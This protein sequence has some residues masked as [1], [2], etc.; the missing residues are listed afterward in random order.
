[1]T[2]YIL[3]IMDPLSLQEEEAI[4]THVQKSEGLLAGEDLLWINWNRAG[5]G[6]YIAT[7]RYAETYVKEHAR[8]KL[9]VA[10]SNQGKP[11]RHILVKAVGEGALGNVQAARPIAP[12]PQKTHVWVPSEE[13]DDQDDPVCERCN[14]LYDEFGGPTPCI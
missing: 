10:A 13:T 4:T 14:R 7:S 8:I 12:K 9:Q 6:V 5:F 2:K 1:M 11:H 3:K